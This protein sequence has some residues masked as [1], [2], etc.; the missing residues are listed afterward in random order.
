MENK[1][2][3]TVIEITQFI[4]EDLLGQ[5]VLD[6]ENKYYEDHK[7]IW[8]K[9]KELERKLDCKENKNGK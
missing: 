2:K 5:I 9:L 8:D 3:K 6:L 4:V 1:Q 7:D